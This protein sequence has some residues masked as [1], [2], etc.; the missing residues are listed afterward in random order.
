MDVGVLCR[1]P[2]LT[3]HSVYKSWPCTRGTAASGTVV[4]PLF[5]SL[6]PSCYSAGAVQGEGAEGKK[7][8]GKYK[9]HWGDSVDRETLPLWLGFTISRF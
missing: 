4:W 6:P 1:F 7:T 3:E 9:W 8:G 2:G 5:I